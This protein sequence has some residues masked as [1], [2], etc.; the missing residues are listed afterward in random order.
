[1]VAPRPG[2]TPTPPLASPFIFCNGGLCVGSTGKPAGFH[3]LDVLGNTLGFFGLGD[4]VGRRRLL[5]QLA[6]VHDEKAEVFHST[7]PVRVFHFH[8]ADD[9]APMPASWSLLTCPAR[10]FQEQGQ[11]PMLPAPDLQ[12]LA[13]RTRAWDQCDQAYTLLEA[14]PQRTFTIRLTISHNAVHPVET[15]GHTLLDRHR[16]RYTGTGVASA[17]AHRQ[18]GAGQALRSGGPPPPRPHTGGWS[19][20]PDG[21]RGSRAHR[22]AGRCVRWHQR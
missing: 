15:E 12:L 10:L 1:M 17:Q 8:L 6:G 4:G 3:A 19:S 9:T 21:A 20:Y 22:H 13:H 18:A 16:G 5:G 11:R 14:Q 2:L 7:A